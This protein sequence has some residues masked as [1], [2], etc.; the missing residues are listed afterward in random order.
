M[1]NSV[2]DLESE[3]PGAA[4]VLTQTLGVWEQLD[5]INRTQPRSRAAWSSWLLSLGLYFWL[6]RL[7]L[8]AQQ[9]NSSCV[10]P[11]P[12]SP[13]CL[14]GIDSLGSSPSEQ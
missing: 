9:G 13:G 8:R 11:A 14:S 3:A 12:L 2:V 1:W 4:G 10:S 6:P 5:G 7:A